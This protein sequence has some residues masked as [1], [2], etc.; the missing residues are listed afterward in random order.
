MLQG[1]LFLMVASLVAGC[2]TQTL[3]PNVAPRKLTVAE[4][5]FYLI[6]P[7]QIRPDDFLPQGTNLRLLR[8]EFGFS[9][10]ML[11]DGRVGYVANEV[12]ADLPE[13]RNDAISTPRPAAQKNTLARF[14]KSEKMEP[15]FQVPDLQAGP[16]ELLPATDELTTL[17][18]NSP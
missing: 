2:A 13:E 5:P 6:G 15:E 7:A 16:E 1:F 9:L 3:A 12:L 17:K 18:K 10:A 8:R 4:T 14:L 11:D